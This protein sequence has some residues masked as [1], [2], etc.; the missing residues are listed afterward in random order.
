MAFLDTGADG[1]FVGAIGDPVPLLLKD[2][3]YAL[4]PSSASK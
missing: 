3:L 4:A 1:Q 2:G